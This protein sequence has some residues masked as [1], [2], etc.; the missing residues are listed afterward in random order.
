MTNSNLPAGSSNDPLA[1]WNQKSKLCRY[2][3]KEDILDELFKAIAV[4]KT[5]DEETINE[6][7]E[8][9]L[10]NYPLC[11]QCAKEEYYDYTEED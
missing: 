3:D 9:Q 1:P 10:D 5:L 11:P 8:D 7:A 2:C 4:D 6:V